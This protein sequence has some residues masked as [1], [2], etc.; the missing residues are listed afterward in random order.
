MPRP[1][2]ERRAD[3]RRERLHASS[4]DAHVDRQ[5]A[6]VR[7]KAPRSRRSTLRAQLRERAEVIEEISRVGARVPSIV[8]RMHENGANDAWNARSRRPMLDEVGGP[9]SCPEPRIPSHFFVFVVVEHAGQVLLVREAKHGQ[10]W[11][12][13]AGGLEAGETIR[14]AAIRETQEEAGVL[15]EPTSLLRVEQQWYPSESRRRASCRGGATS[16]A[17][18]PSGSL[19][20]KQRPDHHSLEAR[21]VRPEAIATAAAA[22]SGGDR[23]RR[24]RAREPAV[25]AARRV[26]LGDGPILARAMRSVAA[27][28]RFLVSAAI[29]APPATTSAPTHAPTPSA[30]TARTS[31]TA[32]ADGAEARAPSTPASS[33]CSRRCR[34]TIERPDNLLTRRQGRARAGC[35][36]STRAS[37]RA[38]TCRATRATT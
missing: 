33:P 32:V 7:A 22:S 37:R 17:R 20:P 1:S 28:P 16:C 10:R 18:V 38:R 14:E 30:P 27:S 6:A 13:P 5:L 4:K 34:A 25:D 31:P 19:T 8:Q 2:H 9:R 3:E 12:A 23:S 11:Y 29:P 26:T 15:V 21:W 36:G 24:A 35:S